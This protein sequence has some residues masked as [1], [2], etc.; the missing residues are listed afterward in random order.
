MQR[1]FLSLGVLGLLALLLSG[2]IQQFVLPLRPDQLPLTPEAALQNFSVKQAALTFGTD[3]K[4][5]LKLQATFKLTNG[6]AIDPVTEIV[7]LSLGGANGSI[8]ATIQTGSFAAKNS[9]KTGLLEKYEFKGNI[10]GITKV[11]VKLPEV[12][13]GFWKLEVEGKGIPDASDQPSQT[14]SLTIGDTASGN[15][16][17]NVKVKGKKANIG[18]FAIAATGTGGDQSAS[19]ALTGTAVTEGASPVIKFRDASG[20][21]T[22]GATTYTFSKLEGQ[23]NVTESKISLSGKLAGTP[24]SEVKLDGTVTGVTL[25]NGKVTGTFNLSLTG[26]AQL[27]K[28]GGKN[29]S[30]NLSLTG[31]VQLTI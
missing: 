31:S 20:S 28:K 16:A 3:G 27:K 6:D 17:V 24:P 18:T 29:Q 19:L 23:I 14:F 2:C 1:K 7:S 11:V 25:T 13:G 22:I 15:I 26:K 4:A 9:E 10:N 12:A 5:E 21:L 8:N 30:V